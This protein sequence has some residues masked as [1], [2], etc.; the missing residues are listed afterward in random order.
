MSKAQKFEVISRFN[1]EHFVTTPEDDL[2]IT[3]ESDLASYRAFRDVVEI[4]RD[5]LNKDDL[6]EAEQRKQLKELLKV[7]SDENLID[8]DDFDK[9]LDTVFKDY[10]VPPS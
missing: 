4:Y 9:Y 7:L 6:N 8:E 1:A 3:T 5:K 10:S 2:V